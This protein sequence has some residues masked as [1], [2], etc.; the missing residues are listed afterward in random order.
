MN[1]AETSAGLK[2]N[3]I[4]NPFHTH[5]GKRAWIHTQ[6]DKYKAT[7]IDCAGRRFGITSESWLYISGINIWRGSK[8]LLRG[9]KRFL[10]CKIHN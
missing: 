8:W 9:G 4:R 5:E 3:K 2:T 10:I 1:Q 7:G 6:G